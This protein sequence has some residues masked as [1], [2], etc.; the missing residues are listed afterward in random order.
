MPLEFFAEDF[1]FERYV[2]WLLDVPMYFVYRDGR[3][4]DLAGQSFRAFMGGRLPGDGI[5]QATIGDFADHMTTAFTDVRVKRFLEMRGADAG[6]PAMMLAQSALWV[7]L[8]YDDAALAAAESLV[9]EQPWEAYRTLRAA[10]PRAGLGAAW[11]GGT[12]RDL[13]RRVVAIAGD[14]LR[15]RA[16]RNSAGADESVYLAPL[17][18]IAAGAPTQAEHWLGR[19]HGAWHGDL[20]RI[21]AEAAI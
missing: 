14:G 6:S 5:G 4:I 2:E 12:L 19:Y 11:G 15:A 3:Y 13:A 17:H 16:R 10:V 8:L 20:S 21:F 1:S 18:D 9:R 7:G